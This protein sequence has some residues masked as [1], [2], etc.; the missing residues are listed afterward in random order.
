MI[1]LEDL[2]A[3]FEKLGT[4]KGIRGVYNRLKWPL[5]VSDNRKV[6]QT[7]HR[8][9]EMFDFALTLEGCSML[10]QDSGK[11]SEILRASQRYVYS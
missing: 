10:S 5:D 9:T 4:A 11:V 7:I 8:Y 2:R 1:T 3:K 6:L